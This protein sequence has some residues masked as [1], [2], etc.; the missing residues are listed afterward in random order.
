ME[1]SVVA[2]ATL[3]NVMGA[4]G[5]LPWPKLPSDMAHFKEL[6]L[7]DEASRFN[8]VIMGVRTW[9]SLPKSCQP[10]PG[11]FNMIVSKERYD[12]L[13]SSVARSVLVVSSLGEALR[14][15]EYDINPISAKPLN[16][17][18]IGGAAL[19][20]EAI[21]MPM[22]KTIHLTRVM[23]EFEGDT[24]FPELDSCWTIDQVAPLIVDNGVMIQFQTLV[25]KFDEQQ[26]LDLVRDIMSRGALRADRTG[27]GTLSVFGAQMRFSLR[28]NRIP[29]LTTKRVFWRGVVEELLWMLRGSTDS[30]EL[31]EKGVHIW[32][33]NGS[34]EYLDTHGFKDREVGDLGPNYGHQWRHFGATYINCKTDYTGQGVDQLANV[35]HTIKTNPSDRRIIMSAW[36]PMEVN[37][38]SLPPCH[39][40]CQ[41]YVADGR[42]SCQMYQRS[43]DMGLGVPFNIASYSLLTIMLARHCNL[44]P[45]EFIH[46]LGD[47]HVYTNHIMALKKQLLRTPTDS[48]TL[49]FKCDASTEV[50]KYTY[51]DCILTGY[52][53]QPAIAMDMSV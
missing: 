48:P 52:T 13:T 20:A 15:L 44:E 18:V 22:C 19:F 30:K 6:T 9:E 37:H 46:S 26:Y 21:A 2:A 29:L 39:T 27:T 42:L 34:R 47:A 32:D 31:S 38:A 43:A 24:F 28:D 11:R 33:D 40:M 17:F 12:E 51:D 23:S 53:P 35:I 4:N 50:D 1:F 25:R 14:V 7:A 45:G 49:S 41:F 5:A 16:V 36:N 10:L 8:V 3:K